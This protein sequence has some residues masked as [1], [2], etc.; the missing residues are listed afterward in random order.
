MTPHPTD[1]DSPT[2]SETPQDPEL[3]VLLDAERRPRGTALKSEVHTLDT[4]LHWAFSCWVQDDDGRVLLTR[5]ALSKRTWPG[6]WTNSFCGHPGPGEATGE[7][8]RRR[9]RRELGMEVAQLQEVLPD[10][11]YRARDASGI[12]ENEVC[13]VWIA[14]ADSVPDPAPDE[15]MDIAWIEPARLVAAVEAAPQLVS[16]WL[17]EELAEPRLRAALGL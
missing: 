1:P 5:R 6:V 10:F 8:I 12:V 16:P 7:A 15:V 14:R 17:V 11:A 3:V 9:G 13:P 2:A 4:P